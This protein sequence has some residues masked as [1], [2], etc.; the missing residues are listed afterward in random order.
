MQTTYPLTVLLN[1]RMFVLHFYQNVFNMTNTH[2][3]KQT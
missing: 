2:L 3:H 1:V